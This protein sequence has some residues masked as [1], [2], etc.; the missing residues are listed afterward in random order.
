[1]SGRHGI[2]MV[3]SAFRESETT[4]DRVCAAV[5]FVAGGLVGGAAAAAAAFVAPPTVA[6]GHAIVATSA[7]AGTLLGAKLSKALRES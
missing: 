7:G 4:A 6:A 1:M 2:G 3:Q 5:G